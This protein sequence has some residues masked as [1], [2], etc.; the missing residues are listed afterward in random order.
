MNLTEWVIDVD[1]IRKTKREFIFCLARCTLATGE[2][3]VQEVVKAIAGMPLK[4]T[5]SNKV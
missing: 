1:Y 5:A 3:F 4:V 2:T